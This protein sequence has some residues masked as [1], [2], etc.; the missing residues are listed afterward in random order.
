MHQVLIVGAGLTGA[1]I[2]RELAEQGIYCEVIDARSHIGGNCYTERDLDTGV[3]VHTYGPHI[4]HTANMEVWE[5]IRR[6]GEFRPYAHHVYANARGRIYSLPINLHTLNQFFGTTMSPSEAESFVSKDLAETILVDRELNFEEQAISLVGRELYEA[7]FKGYTEKQWGMPATQLPGSILKRLPLRFNYDGTYFNH[8]VQAMPVNGYTEIIGNILSHENIN[9][10]LGTSF[11]MSDGRSY[12]HLF[13]SGQLDQ[14]FEFCEGR[15]PY[16]TL[17]FEVIRA[18]G[19]F[20]G[21][22]VLNACDPDVPWTRTTEHKHFAP[23]EQHEGTVCYREISREHAAG[24]IPYYPVNLAGGSSLLERYRLMASGLSNVSF[25][26]RLG[27]FKYMDMDV[28]IADAIGV[29]ARY[30]CNSVS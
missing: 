20:Q 10:S 22:P 26:G 3:M 2:A 27:S 8:P 9:V 21:C 12:D 17:D 14:Y 28:A 15:L 4:F 7:F 5:W 25:V 23:W 29:S 24:D 16:R 6:F 19:D 13:Y 18:E 1:V 30:L 11:C